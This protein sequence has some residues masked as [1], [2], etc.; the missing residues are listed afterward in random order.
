MKSLRVPENGVSIY[1]PINPILSFKMQMLALKEGQIYLASKYI[2]STYIWRQSNS[3]SSI[4]SLF[5]RPSALTTWRKEK[6]YRY[7]LEHPQ[8][9]VTWTMYWHFCL[10]RLRTYFFCDSHLRTGRVRRGRGRGSRRERDQLPSTQGMC[11]DLESNQQPFNPSVHG[12][13][14]NQRSH[15]AQPG[16][17]DI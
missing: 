13:M 8:Y 16:R 4:A 7:F 3:W 15:S 14:P 10:Q 12:T 17:T 6:K 5:H 11:L 2:Q 9:I 1:L